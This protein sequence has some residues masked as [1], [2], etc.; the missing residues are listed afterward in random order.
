MS[1][2]FP[3]MDPYLEGSEMWRGFHHYLADEIVRQL[4]PQIVPKYFADVEV[5]TVFQEIGIDSEHN[6]YSDT[7]VF[8]IAP[9]VRLDHTTVAVSQAPIHRE[10]KLPEPVKLRTLHVYETQTRRRVTSIEI[11]SPANK[12]GDGLRR[13]RRK[14]LRVLRSEIH[15]VE[16]DF[17]RKGERPGQELYDPPLDTDYVILLNRA[18]MGTSRRSEIWAIAICDPLPTLPIPLLA[19]DADVVLDMA[20]TF[21]RVYTDFYYEMRIS[22][23][24]PVPPPALRPKMK[25]WVKTHI[26]GQQA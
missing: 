14:R 15:L 19:P 3:G 9:Q 11:L 2:P 7:A 10:I 20:F 4:N 6:T 1:S 16:I 23:S 21:D 17:L 5:R 18:S 25:S 26:P 12:F 13:Y 22:Y 24:Q 8:E